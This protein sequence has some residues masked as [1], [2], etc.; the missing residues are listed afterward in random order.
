MQAYFLT[1]YGPSETAFQLREVER[2]KPGEGHLLIHTEAFGLN[3]AEVMARKGMYPDSPGLPFIPGYDLVGRVVEVGPGVDPTWIGKRVAS[4]VRFG[5]YA[6]YCVASMHGVAEIPEDMPAGE[7]AALCVQYATAW[8]CA[9]QCLHL[10]PG[11]KVLVHAAAGGVGTALVQLCKWKGCE[12]YGTAGSDEK[13]QIALDNGADHMVNYRKED[14]SKVL[15]AQLGRD[16]LDATFN[17]VAGKTFKKDLKL[18]G[19]GGRLV[20]FG[21]ASRTNRKRG[22]WGT[23]RLLSEMGLIIPL[24]FVGSSKG[25][26]GVNILRI[27][28]YRPQLLAE[29]LDSLVKLCEEG[30]LKPRVG[31]VYPAS[32]LAQ[33]HTHLES[34]RSSGKIIL[35]WDST[36]T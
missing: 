6:E 3:F 14:Y 11:H 5:S 24:T 34:R 26:I 13:C 32:Q 29:A 30:V 12:V 27:G 21:A 15:H 19:A 4:M 33:A 22:K 9:I 16:K 18:L 8:H 20:L 28:D 36:A 2:P 17:A 31:A 35:T 7:A 23:I 10:M 1:Q 25:V